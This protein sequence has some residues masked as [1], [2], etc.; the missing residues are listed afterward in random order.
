MPIREWIAESALYGMCF[1][2]KRRTQRERYGCPELWGVR[3]G[4]KRLES[5]ESKGR[6]QGEG[7]MLGLEGCCIKVW[8]Q[9]CLRGEIKG[10]S[11]DLRQ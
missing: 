2:G 3:K 9:S 5:V 4:R 7:E 8:L 11:P 10:P 6:D 1:I